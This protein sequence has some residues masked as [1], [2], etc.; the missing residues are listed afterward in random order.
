MKLAIAALA[1][2]A[3]AAAEPINPLYRDAT[4]PI[5]A[6]V[7]DLLG[8][9]TLQEKVNQTLN[10]FY[11]GGMGSEGLPPDSERKVRVGANNADT[12]AGPNNDRQWQARDY[13]A[14]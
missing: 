3:A 13:P 11:R 4:Q 12:H 14:C 10:D 6:R 7:A 8:R 9:M 2:A 1:L 5:D